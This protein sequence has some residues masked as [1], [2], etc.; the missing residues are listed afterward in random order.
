MNNEKAME[1]VVV[2]ESLP[3]QQ[4]TSGKPVVY[5]A[6]LG[7]FA[8]GMFGFAYANAEYFVTFC[9]QVGLLSPA[10]TQLRGDASGLT[11]GRPIDVYFSATTGDNLP[12]VFSVEK[13]LQQTHIG[14]RM[15]NDYKFINTTGE[16]IYFKPVHDVFPMA[17]G[18]EDSLI[19][20]ACFCFTQQKIG[21]YE[22]LRMPVIYTFTDKVAEDVE[23]LKMA[24][25]LHRSDKASYEAAQAAY[26]AGQAEAAKSGSH[27]R[28]AR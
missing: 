8:I 2:N 17:A 11:K 12:I 14:E 9:R 10:P 18:A 5:L 3:R 27:S 21:P 20:E 6:V 28:S 19:L 24:Y 7:A 22:T 13:R 15:I 25:T 26:Q 16:T 23:V 4:G 1:T